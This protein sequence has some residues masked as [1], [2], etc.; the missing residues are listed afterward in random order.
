LGA[1][2]I[3][4]NTTDAQTIATALKAGPPKEFLESSGYLMKRLGMM[5]KERSVGAL[6]PSGLTPYHH[7]VLALLAEQPRETQGM[8][9]DALGFDRS[10][11]VGVLD[12]LEQR[13]LIERRRD[14]EDRRRHLVSLTAD[15]RD[16]LERMRAV[17]KEIEA[18]FLAPLDA[19]ERATLHRLL[20]VLMSA[21]DPR[22]PY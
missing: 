12:E 5:M 18:E 6:E 3:P 1:T 19:E 9:A 7:A 8:I 20:R 15:G 13:G 14:P 22:C 4:M 11:L 21:H 16:A 17:S 2:L 10:H